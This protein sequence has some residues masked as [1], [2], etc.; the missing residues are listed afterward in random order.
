MERNTQ[1]K[2]KKFIIREIGTIL[3]SFSNKQ[4]NLVHLDYS[5]RWS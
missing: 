2:A 4:Y 3:P 5:S 1:I